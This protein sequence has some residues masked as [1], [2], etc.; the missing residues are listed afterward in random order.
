MDSAPRARPE[1]PPTGYLHPGY[2]ASL[3][4]FGRPVALPRCGGFVL[5]RPVGAGGDV[6]AMGCYPL[7][8]CRDWSALAGDVDELARRVVSLVLVTDPF[9]EVE[10]AALRRAFPDRC[11]PFKE[12]CVVDLGRPLESS[13]SRHHRR[14]ARRALARVSVER[15]ETPLE[16]LDEWIALHAHL[17]ARHR[18]RGLRA[19]SRSAFAGQLALP[20]AVL[21]RARAGG[22][23][24][25]MQLWLVHGD[26]AYGHVLAFDEAGYALGAPY[27]MYWWAL[28]HFASRVAWCDLGA[29]PGASDDA[30]SGLRRFKQGW[31]TG[32]RTAWLCGRIG[33]RRRYEAL[34]REAG[35]A[36]SA[37]F[38]AYRA[39]ELAEAPAPIAADAA[40]EG[41][42]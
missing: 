17:V 18:I 24:V 36:G 25:G 31:A 9:A 2:A 42:A 23:A 37:Y 8:A 30:A 27:A 39:G 28:E 20:G 5:E 41:A 29:V 13:V 16:A 11:M 12:H 10:P 4:G 1:A 40:R 34:A 38:P 19:F 15:C 21:L 33:D 35:A 22:E 3:V 26:V 7:F 32:T 6:D 14:C